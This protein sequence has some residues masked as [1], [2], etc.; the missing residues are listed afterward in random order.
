MKPTLLVSTWLC[1]ALPTFAEA[2]L[3]EEAVELSAVLA[4]PHELKLTASP[5]HGAPGS[6]ISI[7]IVFTNTGNGPL[8]IPRDRE[9]TLGYQRDGELMETLSPSACDGL[10]FVRVSPGASVRYKQKYEIPNTASG[11]I[12]VFM[13][14]RRDAST[15][16]EVLK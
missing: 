8:W 10:K 12:E 7:T 13:A 4:S 9:V 3:V 6:E 14:G 2:K 11:P 1:F 15:T 5:D 16:V